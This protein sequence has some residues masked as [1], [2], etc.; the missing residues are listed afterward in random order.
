MPV[1]QND[2]RRFL[3]YASLGIVGVTVGTQLRQFAHAGDM[4]H[5]SLDDATAK[6]LK[7][8]H[9]SENAEQDCAN[10][11]HITGTD[12]DEWRPCNLFPG[13]LVNAKGWCAG[14]VKKP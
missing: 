6:A 1:N 8:V 3:K 14:W 7:Y 10:C 12:G 9:A 2:R 5:L 11:M 4:P 13:K